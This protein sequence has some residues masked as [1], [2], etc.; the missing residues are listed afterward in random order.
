MCVCAEGFRLDARSLRG[1]TPRFGRQRRL[2]LRVCAASLTG[3]SLPP[4]HP[5]TSARVNELFG[6][7]LVV[8]R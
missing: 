6:Q 2:R 1:S 7:T 4:S 3:A 8:S 5:R